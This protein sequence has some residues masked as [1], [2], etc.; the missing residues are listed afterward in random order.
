VRGISA[1]SRIIDLVRNF[2]GP[3]QKPRGHS[4]TTLVINLPCHFAATH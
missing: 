2:R 1:A 3:F 4:R